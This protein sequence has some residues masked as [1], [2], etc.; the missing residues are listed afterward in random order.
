MNPYPEQNRCGSSSL[1]LASMVLG[2]VSAALFMT[3]FSIFI[4]ALAIL[5]ALLSRGSGPLLSRAAA[6]L[7]TGIIGIT[8]EIAVL[9]VSLIF[10]ST[11]DLQEYKQQLQEI[12]QEYSTESSGSP[13]ALQEGSA[14]TTLFVPFSEWSYDSLTVRRCAV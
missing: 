10:M 8:L 2:V 11:E 4:G 3:G 12:Y 9:A 6:G 7:V 13:M 1:A 5:F 14:V